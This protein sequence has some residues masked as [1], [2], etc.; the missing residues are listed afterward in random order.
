MIRFS[1]NKTLLHLQKLKMS[2]TKGHYIPAH[3]C[4]YQVIA[5]EREYEEYEVICCYGV[6]K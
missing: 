3:M 2:G 4:G 1:C 6:A 5:M